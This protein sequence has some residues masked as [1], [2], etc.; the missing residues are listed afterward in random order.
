LGDFL[1]TPHDLVAEVYNGHAERGGEIIEGMDRVTF[2]IKKILFKREFL[3]SD[4]HVQ[5]FEVARYV[6][7]GSGKEKYYLAHKIKA[8]SPDENKPEFD[9]ILE[10][11]FSD[12]MK[13]EVDQKLES[14]GNIELEIPS[15][16]NLTPLNKNDEVVAKSSELT[17]DLLMK[18]INEIYFETS[19]FSF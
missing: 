19:D 4:R 12:S 6:L 17:G 7:I 13:A 18:A 15:L 14:N 1:Q 11:T 2:K 9:K 3:T 5:P 16:N 8:K 10:V